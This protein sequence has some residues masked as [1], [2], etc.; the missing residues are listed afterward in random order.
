MVIVIMPAVPAF[1]GDLQEDSSLG[2]RAIMEFQYNS[3]NRGG[4]SIMEQIGN[5][6]FDPTQYIRFYN[7]RSYDRIN[8]ST[9][10]EQ[11]EMQSGVDYETARKEHDK[12]VDPAGYNAEQR[13][14]YPQDPDYPADYGEGENYQRYQQAAEHVS[15]GK[16]ILDSVADCYMLGGRDIRQVPW[17]GN[18]PEIEAIVSEELYVHSKVLI[19][20]DRVVI[21][22][23]ANLNDRSQLGYHDS[24]IAVIVEDPEQIDSYMDGRPFRASKFAATLRRQLFRKHIGLIP[25]QEIE[26]PDQNYE[27]VGVPNFY[28]FGSREDTAVSS[29]SL[30]SYYYN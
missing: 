27:P 18:V 8:T 30:C 1:A 6:G 7:L 15:D 13:G 25:A 14:G 3:I 20:D 10:M 4:Y 12:L 29:V 28:D 26:R 11:A 22:G 23:S 24:E 9:A 5:A 2:T 21:C 17:E 19:A 16:G